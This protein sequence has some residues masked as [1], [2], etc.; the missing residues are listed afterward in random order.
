MMFAPILI[1]QDQ[2]LN[3]YFKKK[4]KQQNTINTSS[5]NLESKN[6]FTDER[7]RAITILIFFMSDQN[8]ENIHKMCDDFRYDFMNELK[9]MVHKNEIEYMSIF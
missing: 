3:K 6:S 4:T 9:K 8:F 1:S 7:I 5:N 2:K